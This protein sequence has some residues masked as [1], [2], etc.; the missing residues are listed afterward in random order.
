M[1]GILPNKANPGVACDRLAPVRQRCAM[2][3]HAMNR[4]QRGLVIALIWSKAIRDSG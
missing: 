2:R 3:G 1:G 4:M